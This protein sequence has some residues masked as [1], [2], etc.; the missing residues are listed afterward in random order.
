MDLSFG[1]KLRIYCL[2]YTT[3]LSSGKIEKINSRSNLTQ[4]D[5]E[6][7]V[8]QTVRLSTESFMA[9]LE[10]REPTAEELDVINGFRPSGIEPY[11]ASELVRFAMMAS[12]NLIH[13]SRKRYSVGALESLSASFAGQALMLDHAWKNGAKTFGFIYDSMI[14]HV[15]RPSPD[16]LNRVLSRSPLPDT[17]RREIIAREGYHQVLAFGVMEKS[18]PMYSEIIYR[19]KADTSWGGSFE[20]DF[21]CGACGVSFD[22]KNCEHFPPMFRGWVE[23]SLLAPYYTCEGRAIAD[24]NSFVFAGNCVQAGILP[25]SLDNFVML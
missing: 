7:N 2:Q 15:P 14:V 8:E 22:N 20:G 18:H 13:A 9:L 23:D 16:A 1:F 4:P 6:I 3:D 12:N 10:M 11:T 24:E 5:P 21:I 17:D 19:R 25:V